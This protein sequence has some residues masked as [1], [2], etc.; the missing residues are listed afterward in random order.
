MHLKKSDGT[1]EYSRHAEAKWV[2]ERHR[3]TR[4]N[5]WSSAQACNAVVCSILLLALGFGV[6][7]TTI[8][9]RHGAASFVP[10]PESPPDLD[11]FSEPSIA[12][13]VLKRH[14]QALHEACAQDLIGLN[15]EAFRTRLDG[16]IA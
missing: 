1:A 12:A 4:P 5:R 3:L 15:G 8:K 11:S 13:A 16:W 14:A 7:S 6:G 9:G 2:E 10:L